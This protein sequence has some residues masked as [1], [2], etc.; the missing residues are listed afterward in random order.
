MVNMLRELA[1]NAKKTVLIGTIMA[2]L[3]GG[4]AY[5]EPKE[6]EVDLSPGNYAWR[7]GVLPSEERTLKLGLSDNV[8][9]LLYSER[10]NNFGRQ[11]LYEQP[12]GQ[13]VQMYNSSMG[14]MDVGNFN[15]RRIVGAGAG[16]EVNLS[17]EV[18]AFIKGGVTEIPRSPQSLE[19]WSDSGMINSRLAPDFSAGL[20]FTLYEH[21][22]FKVMVGPELMYNPFTGPTIMGGFSFTWGGK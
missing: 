4:R 5:A 1:N 2:S 16:L 18:T 21:N 11:A 13:N 10:I 3:L 19:G 22:G 8:S 6:V 7:G 17:K 9:L 14:T 12:F 15:A 20:G